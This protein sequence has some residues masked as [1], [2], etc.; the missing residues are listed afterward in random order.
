MNKKAHTLTGLSLSIKVN[1]EA[2]LE[3]DPSN[4]QRAAINLHALADRSGPITAS[5]IRCWIRDQEVK[6]DSTDLLDA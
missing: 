1:G 2:Y 5:A 3:F 6:V 4:G